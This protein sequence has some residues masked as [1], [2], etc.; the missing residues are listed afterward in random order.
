MDIV[1]GFNGI[2]ANGQGTLVYGEKAYSLVPS[3]RDW[4]HGVYLRW[5]DRF[6]GVGYWLFEKSK[7]A[8]TSSLAQSYERTPQGIPA[9][10]EGGV[11]DNPSRQSF[12]V[13]EQITIGTAGVTD[14]EYDLLLGLVQSPCVEMLIGGTRE[15]PVWARVTIIPATYTRD[16]PRSELPRLRDFE[17]AIVPP[18]RNTARL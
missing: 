16:I 5:L 18:Q 11:I 6:G 7:H 1:T 3:L 14:K 4:G 10:P 9:L 2:I 17:L 15:A 13:S 8:V 12:A